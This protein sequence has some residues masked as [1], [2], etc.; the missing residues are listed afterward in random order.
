VAGNPANKTVDAN[1]GINKEKPG[2]MVILETRN[3]TKQFAGGIVALRDINLQIR[4]GELVVLAGA[5]GSGKTVLARH[6]NGLL[7]P[8]KGEVLVAG[9]PVTANLAEA[10][11]R[12]GLVFQDSDSQIVGET[13]AADV[14]FGPE[15]LGL[16]PR[17]VKRRVAAALAVTGL[18]AYAADR[19]HRLSGGQKRKLVI[20]GV[21]AMRPEIIV[22][23]EPF[24]GLD[25]PGV[26]Q[27]LTQLVQ[28]RRSGHTLLVITHELEKILAHADRLALMHSGQIVADGRPEELLDRVE[29]YGIKKPFGERRPVETMTWLS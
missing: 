24:T 23:D 1:F 13:V 19:P 14:A 6:L 8:S 20:A 28:L 26:V 5:N 2:E 25:F 15:N 22:W 16:T 12:V 7:Q 18:T 11:R 17:E 9:E 27:V 4:R 29:T 10:R 21:L 3:L